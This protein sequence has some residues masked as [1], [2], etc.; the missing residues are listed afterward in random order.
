MVV[1]LGGIFSILAREFSTLLNQH[2]LWRVWTR[3]MA[4]IYTG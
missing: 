4:T 3:A 2:N 1:P